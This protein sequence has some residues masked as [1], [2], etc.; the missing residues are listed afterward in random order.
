MKENDF[1]VLT[2]YPKYRFEKYQDFSKFNVLE[3]HKGNFNEFYLPEL[4]YKQ[5]VIEGKDKYRSTFANSVLPQNKFIGSKLIFEINNQ[6]YFKM[7]K[8]QKVS[9]VFLDSVSFLD[10]NTITNIIYNEQLYKKVPL[11]Y[12]VF[13]D[14]RNEIIKTIPINAKNIRYEALG[15]WT[16]VTFEY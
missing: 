14:I 15:N 4:T 12:L 6:V 1:I 3:I 13:S 5:A 11:L 9:F 7:K 8:G 2:Y 10:E 16:I